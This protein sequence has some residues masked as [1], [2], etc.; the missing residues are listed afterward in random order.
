LTTPQAC[1]EAAHTVQTFYRCR[2]ECDGLKIDQAKQLKE[3]EKEM[4][5]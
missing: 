4:A 5:S 1:T 3:L 2:K